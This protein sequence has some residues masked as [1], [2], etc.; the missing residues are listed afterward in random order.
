M[1]M[2]NNTDEEDKNEATAYRVLLQISDNGY[3]M[4]I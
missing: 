4:I 3:D 1:Y 2:K